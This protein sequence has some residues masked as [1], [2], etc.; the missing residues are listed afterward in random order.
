M[1]TK[2]V[3]VGLRVRWRRE[4]GVIVWRQPTD[5]R[6]ARD[7]RRDL[8]ETM[9]TDFH[10]RREADAEAGRPPAGEYELSTPDRVF[11]VDLTRPRVLVRLD[12]DCDRG[13]VQVPR[14]DYRY[15]WMTP[16]TLQ[17]SEE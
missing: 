2:D 16:R 10:A 17:P 13:L 8:Y 5:A 3:A 9:S 7:V 4:R 14:E 6:D 11:S 12:R 15:V 1:K